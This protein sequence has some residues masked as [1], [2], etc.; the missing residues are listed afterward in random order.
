MFVRKGFWV[1][2]GIVQ[3]VTLAVTALAA[4]AL[5]GVAAGIVVLVMPRPSERFSSQPASRR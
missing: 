3:A 4:A 2:A 1:A 5:A